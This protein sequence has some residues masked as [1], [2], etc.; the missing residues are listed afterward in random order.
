MA[1][2]PFLTEKVGYFFRILDLNGNGFLQGD[3]FEEMAAKIIKIMKLEEGSYRE[4]K[5]K[6]KA[7][8]LFQTLAKDMNPFSYNQITEQEWINFFLSY[9]INDEERLNDYKEL[10]FNFMF[11]FFDQNRDGF[12]NKAEYQDFFKIF[13]LDQS[14][15]DDAFDKLDHSKV[16]KVSRY[17]LMAALEDY[18]TS[19][20]EEVKG[21]WVFGN[22]QSVP[23]AENH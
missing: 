18:F 4:R 20:E 16:Q 6:E 14:F 11:D 15:V 17:D 10:I 9:V 21:N 3:D 19:T 2:H 8:K 13:G 12:I 22:W 7:L 23:H 1:Q 5:V